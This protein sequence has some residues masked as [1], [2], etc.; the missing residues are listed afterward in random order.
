MHGLAIAMALSMVILTLLFM[1][2]DRKSKKLSGGAP[3][4]R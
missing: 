1:F 4:T 2:F 3:T